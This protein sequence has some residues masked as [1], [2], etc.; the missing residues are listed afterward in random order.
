MTEENNKTCNFVDLDGNVYIM[1]EFDDSVYQNVLP[2]FNKRIKEIANT[3]NPKITVY[4]SSTGGRASVL[5]SLLS[6]FEFARKEGIIIETVVMGYAHSCGS[7]LAVC[8]DIRKMYRYANHL[9][10]LG[11]SWNSVQTFKQIDRQTKSTQEHFDNIVEI[12]KEHT[13]MSEKKIREELKDDD[14]LLNAEECLK[15]GLVDEIIG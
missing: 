5:L 9:M 2:H 6:E 8:G 3:K 11:T 13:K 10:H 14:Y 1:G 12:Y 4:I 7:L 15:Y